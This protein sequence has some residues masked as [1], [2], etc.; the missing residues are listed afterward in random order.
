MKVLY[1]IFIGKGSFKLLV[2]IFGPTDIFYKLYMRISGKR[3]I[4]NLS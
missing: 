2:V 3:I 4:C 1:N